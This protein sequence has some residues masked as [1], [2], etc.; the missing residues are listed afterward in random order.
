MFKV[1]PPDQIVSL[2]HDASSIAAQK[3]FGLYGGNMISV[4]IM[5]SIIGGING[6][7]MTL[8]RV[9]LAM[10]ERRQ[11]PGSSVFVRLEEDSKTPVNAQILLL[12]L[13]FVYFTV[14]DT[15]RLTNITMFSIWIFYVFCFWGVIR[16]RRRLPDAPRSYRV[17][18]YPVVPLLA[19]AGAL[20]VIYGMF[21]SQ[22]LN[23]VFAVGLILI[24]LP[25]LHFFCGDRPFYQSLSFRKRNLF[26]IAS[27][28]MIGMLFMFSK[29]FD[30][31]PVLVVATEN[32]NRPVAFTGPTGEPAG[33]AIDLITAMAEKAGYKV[34]FRPIAFEHLFNAVNNKSV[35]VATGIL[36][37][38]EQRQGL[39]AFTN[40]Y[41]GSELAL[42]VRS[43]S[44]ARSLADLD[45]QRIVVR[46]GTVAEQ[47]L[48][49]KTEFEVL[50]IDDPA[51][52]LSLYQE[53]GADAMVEDTVLLSL[54]LD[55]N[56]LAGR[57]IP[58]GVRERYAFAYNKGN[59]SLGEA[60]N[61]AL[62]ELQN[63]GEIDK[64]CKKWNI[65]LEK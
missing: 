61:G 32:S 8:S 14:V 62:E 42:L 47:F 40:S 27:L 17:P 31:R 60:L 9:I 25:V 43:D 38:N 23:A 1:L 52:A 53:G 30:N 6:Y 44:P 65:R 15:E 46:K 13:S 58:L 50:S 51:S 26:L 21:V 39:V 28:I 12:V 48:A 55:E 35:D 16:T 63:S 4:G 49:G 33:F 19:I 41:G 57:L 24:G 64:L 34:Q 10:S 2:G 22:P 37:I 3:L 7:I 5:I 45:G 56:K 29:V 54:W 11:M 36:T 18:L 59:V 20:Y